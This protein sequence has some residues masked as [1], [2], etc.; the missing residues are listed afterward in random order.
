MSSTHDGRFAD[1]DGNVHEANIEFIAGLGITEGCGAFEDYTYCPSRSVTRAQMAV[2]LSRA[3]HDVPDDAP[4]VSRFPDV[5]DGAWYLRYVER[6]ADLGIVRLG[7]GEAFRP[8]DPITRA[9]MAV[10]M[11][12]AFDS[13]NEV[14][15]EGLFCSSTTR[16]S[17][18]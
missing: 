18:T 3:L 16:A 12:R 6:L 1:D 10:W 9:E 11:A 15:P 4:A 17:Q 2:L 5:P 8:S 13:V 7:A 14:V